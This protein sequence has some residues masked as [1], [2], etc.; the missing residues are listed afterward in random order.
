MPS[1]APTQFEVFR[2]KHARAEQAQV[3][4]EG[5]F[6]AIEAETGAPPT[7]GPKALVIAETRTN[8]LVV[9][10]SPADMAE[11]RELITQIDQP[12][13]ETVNEIRVFKL[14]HSLASTLA[15]VLQRAARGQGSG[16]ETDAAAENLATLLRMVT[17]DA[18]GSAAARIR[19]TRGRPRSTPT[20]GPMRSSSRRRRTA[21]R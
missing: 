13:G 11:V 16:T 12:G 6:T 19:R 8:S 10:A 1:A 18:D 2:L 20:R 15:P 21:C 3:V 4:V 5:L 14:R 9:R 7:F 17:I